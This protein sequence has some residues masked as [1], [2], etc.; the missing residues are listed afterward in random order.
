MTSLTGSFGDS[1]EYW[2]KFISHIDP[3][4]LHRQDAHMILFLQLRWAS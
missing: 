1:A 2:L 4:S 3:Y